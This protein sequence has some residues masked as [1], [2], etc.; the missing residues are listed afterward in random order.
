MVFVIARI[1]RT[2]KRENPTDCITFIH[3]NL[4]CTRF[5]SCLTNIV[6]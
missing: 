1:N 2:G 5:P 4:I 6:P 3:K